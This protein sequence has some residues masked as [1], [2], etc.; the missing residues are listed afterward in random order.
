VFDQVK[1]YSRHFTSGTILA[2]A[3][4]SLAMGVL[5]IPSAAARQMLVDDF[6]VVGAASWTFTSGPEFPGAIGSFTSGVGHNSE[7]GAHLI[8]DFS[9]GGHYVGAEIKLPQPLAAAAVAF[10]IKSPPGIHVVLRVVDETGQTLHYTPPRPLGALAATA[11][12][13][14]VIDLAQPNGYWGGANDGLLHGNLQRISI[15]AADPVEPG[16]VGA[17][18]F[19][20]VAVTDQ[21]LTNLDPFMPPIVPVPPENTDLNSR[22]GVNIHFMRDAAALDAAHSVGFTWVRMDLAWAEVETVPGIYDFSAPDQL[23][24]DLETRGM[25]VLFILDYGNPLYTGGERLPPTTPAALE[26]FGCYAEVAARHF[27]G[28][29]VSYEVWNEPN[30]GGF[31]PPQPDAAHYAALVNE[32]ITRVRAGDPQAQVVTGGL[33]RG[34]YSFLRSFLAAQGGVGVTAIGVHPYRATAPETLTDELMAWRSIVSQAAQNDLPTWA[35]E[36]GYSSAWFGDG[37][38]SEAQA[39]HAV[40]VVRELLTSWSAGFPLII[41]YDLRDDGFDPADAEQNFGLLAHDGTAKPATQA[42]R[43]LTVAANRR[44]LVGFLSVEPSTVHALR[45]DGSTDIVVVLWASSSQATLRVPANVT[46]VNLLGEPLALRPVAAQRELI[47]N[48]TAGPVY[49]TFP[50]QQMFLPFVSR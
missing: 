41:Y 24:A 50:K 1:H 30:V 39:R 26:A 19:D 44:R 6:E 40:L 18:D 11:W 28:Q 27:A 29:G 14:Q 45:L 49:L 46:A 5:H 48:E 3:L 7:H 16:A 23:I 33:S 31:W 13:R 25:R 35:T 34:D 42:V 8:Y 36:W 47:V 32:A 15:L 22:L 2:L 37:H 12:Y 17:I 20:D 21:L 43:T 9:R 4:L 38:A 10:W